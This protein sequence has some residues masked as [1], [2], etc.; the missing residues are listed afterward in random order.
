MSASIFR[1]SRRNIAAG[2]ASLT[3]LAAGA[4]CGATVARAQAPISV[5]AAADV[6]DALGAII[7]AFEARDGAKVRATFGSTGNLARQIA[8]GAPFDLFLSADESFADRL[9]AE[10]HAEGP[11]ALYAVGRLALVTRREGG[12]DIAGG[13]DAVATALSAGR[14]RRFAIAN[15][16]HAPYGMRAK[17]A[18]EKSGLWGR[19]GPH[20]VLGENVAQATQYVLTGAA[21]AGITAYPL[22]K[23]S[24]AAPL[25]VVLIPAETHS[26]LRQRM[27]LTRRGVGSSGTN[28]TRARALFDLIVSPAGQAMLQ[29]YGFERP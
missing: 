10:G 23:S 11:G 18:L 6:R 26:P 1:P 16:E 7:A 25:A 28:A 21:E 2:I 8:Q 13:L 24:E 17:E 15:P 29:A 3:G 12:L 19:L 5:A 14:L 9:I 27:V 22:T 4:A 20:L